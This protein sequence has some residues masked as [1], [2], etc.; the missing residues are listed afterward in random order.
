[1]SAV[2]ILQDFW[3]LNMKLLKKIN[4]LP[5]YPG[6]KEQ[7][8]VRGNKDVFNDGLGIHV[9]LTFEAI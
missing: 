6:K 1:M 3:S 7:G 4:S 8:R 5:T 2:T 9:C